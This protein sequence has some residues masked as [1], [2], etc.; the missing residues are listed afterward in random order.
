MRRIGT[1]DLVGGHGESAIRLDNLLEAI[2]DVQWYMVDPSMTVWPSR[3]DFGARMYRNGDFVPWDIDAWAP[4][5]PSCILGA[6]KAPSEGRGRLYTGDLTAYRDDHLGRVTRPS[7]WDG[8]TYE[9][10]SWNGPC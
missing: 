6:A 4:A 3:N 2:G 7:S 1:P 10:R 5:L 9:A 8:Y